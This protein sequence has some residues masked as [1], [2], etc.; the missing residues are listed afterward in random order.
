MPRRRLRVYN[1]PDSVCDT[2][3]TPEKTVQTVKVPLNKVFPLL[4][5]AVHGERTRLRDFE[6]D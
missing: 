1:G 4:A 5:D 2:V 3:V 6:N